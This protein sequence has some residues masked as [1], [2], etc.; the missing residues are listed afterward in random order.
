MSPS[1]LVTNIAS[2]LVSSIPYS[3][4][5]IELVTYKA[6]HKIIL[7]ESAIDEHTASVYI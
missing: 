3:A 5:H 7:D 6:G 2:V 4:H 1:D